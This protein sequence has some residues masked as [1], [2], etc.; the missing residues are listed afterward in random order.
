M[1]LPEMLDVSERLYTYNE[2]G[3]AP[4]GFVPVVWLVHHPALSDPFN[5]SG[6]CI[7]GTLR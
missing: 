4:D 1:E 3:A 2:T 6:A 7:V 5:P